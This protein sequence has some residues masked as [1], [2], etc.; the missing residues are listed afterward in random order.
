MTIVQPPPE[1]R[2]PPRPLTPEQAQAELN[3]FCE[4][5]FAKRQG[6]RHGV[7]TAKARW[8][9]PLRQEAVARQLAAAGM[10]GLGYLDFQA[11]NKVLG[12]FSGKSWPLGAELPEDRR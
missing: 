12:E 9:P 7:R 11:V 3:A 2:Q 6:V 8:I 1:V 5:I 10:Q 4:L